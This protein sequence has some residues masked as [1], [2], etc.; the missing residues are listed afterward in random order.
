MVLSLSLSLVVSSR[1]FV[2]LGRVFPAACRLVMMFCCVF[3]ASR[4]VCAFFFGAGSLLG[5]FQAGFSAFFCVL[6]QFVSLR[7]ASWIR[8][9][10]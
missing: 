8:K 6:D 7:E 2:E 10:T 1:V 5:T 9:G 3:V 4:K